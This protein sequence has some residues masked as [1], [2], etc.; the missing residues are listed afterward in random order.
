M[1]LAEF[2]TGTMIE[3]LRSSDREVSIAQ[4]RYVEAF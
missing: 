4:H 3:M 1:V 2:L